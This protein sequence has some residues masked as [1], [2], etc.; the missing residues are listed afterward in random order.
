[1][2]KEYFLAK[3]LN[4][5]LSQEELALFKADPDYETYEKIRKYSKNLSVH[6]FDENQILTNIL[7]AKKLVK[8]PKN[9]FVSF[10]NIAAIFIAIFGLTII[11]VNLLSAKKVFTGQ[12][13][14]KTFLLPDHSKV[15]LNNSSVANYNNFQWLFN[16]KIHLEGIAYFHV[17]KGKTFTVSTDLGNVTVVGTQFEV[18]SLENNFNVVCF[19]GKVK[20]NYKNKEIFLTKGM[21]V[22]FEN[23]IEKNSYTKEENPYEQVISLDFKDEKLVAILS[24]LEKAYHLKMVSNSNSQELFTGKL[25]TDN[26]EMALSI[27]SKTYHLEYRKSAGKIFFFDKK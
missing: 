22:N 21:R 1:M 12:F 16:R 24:Q 23:G 19:E 13:S 14:S 8:K 11:T 18:Q 9:P 5:E 2:E 17:T 6:D 27:I 26:L 15:I 10:Y 25:P 20:V 3:W 4:N 7:Q